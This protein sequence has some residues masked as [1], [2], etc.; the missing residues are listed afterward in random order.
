MEEKLTLDG[1]EE[2]DGVMTRLQSGLSGDLFMGDEA[3]KQIKHNYGTCS[4]KPEC[5]LSLIKK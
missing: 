3:R 4:Q 1:G 5:T 2:A